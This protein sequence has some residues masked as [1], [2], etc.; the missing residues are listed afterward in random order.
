MKL[1]AVG[2]LGRL[3]GFGWSEGRLHPR[4][5]GCSAICCRKKLAKGR[6]RRDVAREASRGLKYVARAAISRAKM[7][8]NI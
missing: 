5:L 3:T 2:R 7:L 6:Q 4:G 8:L 1:Y